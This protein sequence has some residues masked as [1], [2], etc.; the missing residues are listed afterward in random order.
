MRK[1]F[2]YGNRGILRNYEEALRFCGA[3]AVFS[4]DVS[5]A[6]DCDGL[7]LPGGGDIDPA[8]YG[9]ENEGSFN[10]DRPRDIQEIE[11]IRQFS[12]TRRP[13][14][15]ICKGIQILNAAFGGTIDQDIETKAA[16]RWEERTGDKVHKVLAPEDSFLYPIYG[17]EFFVTS[18]HH[19][20]VKRAA[21]GFSIAA[22]A[23]DDVIEAL[24]NR[25]KKIFAVQWHPERMAFRKSR[26]DTVDGRYLF[27]FFLNLC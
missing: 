9:E 21:A 15:G 8:L 5:H 26:L 11:L 24:E 23:E 20:A 12:V 2:L 25:E 14:L 3:R 4:E 17:E 19:Q 18:A 22:K 6:L 16:H 10:I 27:E 1:I 13:I 7:L